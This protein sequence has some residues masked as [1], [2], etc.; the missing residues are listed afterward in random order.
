MKAKSSS[1]KWRGGC[2]RTY[3]FPRFPYTNLSW[4]SIERTAEIASAYSWTVVHKKPFGSVEKPEG[5]TMSSLGPPELWA[6][7]MTPENVG[8]CQKGDQIQGCHLTYQSQSSEGEIAIWGSQNKLILYI[9]PIKEN[10]RQ[11]ITSNH[12]REQIGFSSLM[13][14]AK[15]FWEQFGVS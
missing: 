15:R 5:E 11:L 10:G 7:G 3:L 14:G 9:Y 2:K 4:A 1:G 12:D 13:W 8:V 6:I